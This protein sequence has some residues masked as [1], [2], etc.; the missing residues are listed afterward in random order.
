MDGK[1]N[2]SGKMTRFAFGRRDLSL[3]HSVNEESTRSFAAAN[4]N[5]NSTI[6]FINLLNEWHFH[7]CLINVHHQSQIY[8]HKTPNFSIQY[9]S[10]WIEL[11]KELTVRLYRFQIWQHVSKYWEPPSC[12]CC[13]YIGNSF[14]YQGMQEETGLKTNNTSGRNTMENLKSM[15]FSGQTGLCSSPHLGLRSP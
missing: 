15:I 4:C 3:A 12:T 9:K 7:W 13:R 8:F 11:R 2:L 10:T 1:Q 14:S 6:T 5:N